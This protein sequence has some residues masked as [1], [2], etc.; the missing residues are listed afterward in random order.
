MAAIFFSLSFT[1]VPW[2]SLP[3]GRSNAG[4]STGHVACPRGRAV[5]EH[6]NLIG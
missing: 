1:F 4:G 3:K 5:I 6:Q 2:K